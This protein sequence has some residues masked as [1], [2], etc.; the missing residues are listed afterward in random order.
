MFGAKC[1][2]LKESDLHEFFRVCQRQHRLD[3]KSAAFPP[4][5]K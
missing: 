2:Y 5:Q 3:N 4:T 1:K